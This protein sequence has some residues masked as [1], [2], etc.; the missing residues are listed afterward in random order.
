MILRKTISLLNKTF[1]V[2]I[3][4]DLRE[5]DALTPLEKD[6]IKQN[7]DPIVEC[8]GDFSDPTFT[9]PSKE[10]RF[11]SQF[12]VVQLFNTDDYEDAEDRANSYAGTVTARIVAAVAAAK[13]YS[14]NNGDST[15]TWVQTT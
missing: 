2:Q 5:E 11:P 12:P 10:L 1:H 4:L 9:L 13:T 14:S 3:G 15:G 8:G 7:G 6:A